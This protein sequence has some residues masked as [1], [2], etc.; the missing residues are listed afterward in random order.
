MR[1]EGKDFIRT[2]DADNVLLSGVFGFSDGD[3]NRLELLRQ[4]VPLRHLFFEDKLRGN[5]VVLLS[6]KLNITCKFG[7]TKNVNGKSLAASG[8]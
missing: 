1:L 4:L 2:G 8:N 7:R 3:G 5:D 6:Y